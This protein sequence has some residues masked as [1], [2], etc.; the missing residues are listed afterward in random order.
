MTDASFIIS[1]I[2]LRNQNTWYSAMQY[3][4]QFFVGWAT[5]IQDCSTSLVWFAT[6]IATIMIH[7]SLHKQHQIPTNLQ[8]HHIRASPR[9]YESSI[10][11]CSQY[12][13]I[14]QYHLPQPAICTSTNIDHGT[15]TFLL[16]IYLFLLNFS[17]SVQK[18]IIFVNIF[19]K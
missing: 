12:P 14:I 16:H 4:A 9:H 8:S 7:L 13:V 19:H 1:Q 18:A 11:R 10:P 5:T 2:A 6:Q 3:I 15:G 17:G